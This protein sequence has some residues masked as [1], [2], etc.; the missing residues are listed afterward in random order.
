MC[1]CGGNAHFDSILDEKLIK[2]TINDFKQATKTMEQ[3]LN[4]IQLSAKDI[5]SNLAKGNDQLKYLKNAVSINIQFIED[6]LNKVK[7]EPDRASV[8][9]SRSRTF[10]W[11]LSG[12]R[13]DE[14]EDEDELADEK[15]HEDF[16]IPSHATLLQ[17]VSEMQLQ[18]RWVANTGLDTAFKR[19]EEANKEAECTVNYQNDANGDLRKRFANLQGLAVQVQQDTAKV[20]WTWDNE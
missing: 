10:P 16:I 2:E 5:M 20:P 12:C 11:A 6:I 14:D 1:S 18:L 7:E 13:E 3:M 4:T 17:E 15:L 19:I 9:A 8:G